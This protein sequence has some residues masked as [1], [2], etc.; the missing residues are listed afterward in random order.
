MNNKTNTPAIDREKLRATIQERLECVKDELLEVDHDSQTRAYLDGQIY[1]LER[2]ISDI[3]FG[4]WAG[5]DHAAA[6]LRWIPVSERLPDC[7]G[8][9][10]CS[11]VSTS[12]SSAVGVWQLGYV[13]GKW[14]VGYDISEYWTVQA[15]QPM[16][17][18]YYTEPTDLHVFN[19]SKGYC[20]FGCCKGV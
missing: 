8:S 1:V 12:N 18:P 15:W 7:D 11:C 10:L 4:L 14:G 17:K 13:N 9:F 16:P 6:E 5:Y 3:D 19:F 2:L 20:N